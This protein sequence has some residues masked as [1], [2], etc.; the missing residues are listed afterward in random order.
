MDQL[1]SAKKLLGMFPPPM[2]A[3]EFIL[4]NPFIDSDG[5]IKRPSNNSIL[6]RK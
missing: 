4:R 6:F 1:D 3:R 2:N 5:H